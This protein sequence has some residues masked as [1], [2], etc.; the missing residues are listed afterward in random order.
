MLLTGIAFPPEKGAEPKFSD[1]MADEGEVPGN[2]DFIKKFGN[3]QNMAVYI[4]TFVYVPEEQD[5]L[6]LLGSD[7]GVKVWLNDNI[8]HKNNVSRGVFPDSDEVKIT[9]QKGW[10]MI[11]MKVVQGGGGWGACARIINPDGSPIKDLKYSL[12][13][14]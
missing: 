4:G 1:I 13:P 10:N 12:L 6:L 5:A 3:A 7:D 14:E 11:V 2:V 8:V 9:L